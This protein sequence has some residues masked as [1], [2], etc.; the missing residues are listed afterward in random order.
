MTIQVIRRDQL[1][2]LT[3]VGQGGQGVV[4]RAPN[5]RTKFAASMV[6]KE[7]KDHTLVGIDFAVLVAMPALVE[8]SLT[9]AQAQRLVSIA[10][11]PCRIVE[12]GGTPTG[13]VMPAI[14]ETFFIPLT[15]AKGVTRTTAE[16]QH[17]LNHPTV[18]AARG[19]SLDDVQ[20]YTLLREAASGLAFLHRNG[21]CVG[22]I[23]PK[24]LLFSLTP[25]EAVYFIDCDAM[26][27]NGVSALPQVETPGWSVP[28]GQELATVYSDTYK[29]GLL[30]LRLLAGD[31]DTTD[32]QRIPAITPALLRQVITDTLTNPPESRPLPDAWTYVLGHAIEHAQ[33]DKL[34][35]PPQS[36]PP[37]AP[38]PDPAIPVVRSRPPAGRSAQPARA[39]PRAPVYS[40]PPA[41]PGPYSAPPVGPTAP[42]PLV[43]SSPGTRSRWAVSVVLVAGAT[44][45]ALIAIPLAIAISKHHQPSATP[46]LTL[47]PSLSPAP[48][49]AYTPPPAPVYTPPPAPAHTPSPA[50]P[51]PPTS[52]AIPGLSAFEGTWHAHQSK[53]VI[54][55]TGSGRL[56]YQDAAACPSCSFATM[57]TATVDFTLTSMSNGTATGTI[58]ASSDTQND[59]VGGSVTM[60]LVTAGSGEAIQVTMGKMSDWNYC[61]PAAGNY[62]GG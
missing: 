50:L 12:T 18:L 15:T 22:D 10:A 43:P 38:L 36:I 51:P 6:Y 17:L 21:V 8:D 60:T 2:V 42:P 32:P 19:I 55:S 1:G 26:R 20:R 31:Q 35:A 40:H 16:I 29:L 58:T 30:A 27:I 24:N 56:T 45:I 13:F 46:A 53:I 54:D 37:P 52:T 4:Y 7:Y 14:P 5:V 47:Q 59:T 11:W 48:A 62:C 49:P 39:A 25:H 34:H 61:N 3:K 9:Y 23:S 41:G 44:V 33:H 28:A 57:P